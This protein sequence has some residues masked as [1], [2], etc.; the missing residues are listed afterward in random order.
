MAFF[1]LSEHHRLKLLSVTELAAD[2]EELHTERLQLQQAV[3]SH[4]VIDQ[5]IGVIVALGQ[6]PPEESWRVL[7][8]VSQ[9]TNTKVR[10]VAENILLFA[11][12]GTLP[13]PERIE[14]DRAITRYRA[15]TS[16]PE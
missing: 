13:E 3:T 4:A 6:I 16:R 1:A 9:R 10:T 8:D 11:Q 14:L 12:G 2:H 5:A 15:C 7:Q